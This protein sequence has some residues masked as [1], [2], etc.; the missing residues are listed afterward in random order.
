M[1]RLILRLSERRILTS[2]GA[3]TYLT[4]VSLGHRRVSDAIDSLKTVL[5][6]KTYDTL[7]LDSGLFLMVALAAFCLI[8]IR[9]SRDARALR[10]LYLLLTGFLIVVSHYTLIVFNVE[11]IHF[12]QYA[13]L[14]VPV[15][16]L[17]GRFGETVFWV[18]LLGALDESY[19]YFVL[20][21]DNNT[22][23]LDFNDIIL[24]LIG[25]G[26]GV[27]L[28]YITSR[29]S[30]APSAQ[31]RKTPKR[32]FSPVA[33][34]AAGILLLAYLVIFIPGLLPFSSEASAF[35]GPS[36]LSRRPLPKTFWVEPKVGKKFH[37]F[38]PSEG[39]IAAALLIAFYT[40]MDCR[41]SGRRKR[42]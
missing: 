32:L 38:G 3:V 17:V 18:T 28:I 35:A 10:L 39:M 21:R 15:F 4:A 9:E 13:L 1:N 31:S 27:V 24:N 6:F 30:G 26:I 8:K 12:P 22:V 19:Q 42:P 14:A 29:P 25:A 34:A 5:S 20:Y 37:I 40:T 11:N 33:S 2:L 41:N 36:V 16:A 7:M 23:Y